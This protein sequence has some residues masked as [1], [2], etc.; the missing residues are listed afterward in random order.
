MIR[1][2]V[3]A[4]SLVRCSSDLRIFFIYLLLQTKTF[5][6]ETRQTIKMLQELYS[7]YEER[8][9]KYYICIILGF[10]ST[11]LLKKGT[12]RWRNQTEISTTKTEV[13]KKAN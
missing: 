7:N 9:Q 8:M 6:Q 4:I 13:G 3:S 11:S 12:S 10:E 5:P 2:G 1:G